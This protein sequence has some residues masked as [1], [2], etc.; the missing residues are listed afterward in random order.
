MPISASNE[1]SAT[2][3][4]RSKPDKEVNKTFTSD[5]EPSS[6]LTH[7][8][9]NLDTPLYPITPDLPDRCPHCGFHIRMSLKYDH[10]LFHKALSTLGYSGSDWP[11]EVRTNV[12]RAWMVVRFAMIAVNFGK[13]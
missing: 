1:Y 5:N 8:M 9:F 4:D 12:F 2:I 11:T 6:L 13:I 7:S 10:A 3:I